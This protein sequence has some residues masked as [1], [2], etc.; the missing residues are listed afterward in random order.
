[1]VLKVKREDVMPEDTDHVARM[2][3]QM[4]HFTVRDTGIG[5]AP[6][7]LGHA[8]RGVHAGGCLDDAQVRRHGAGAGDL[9]AAERDDGRDDV[10]RERRRPGP[11]QCLPL[12]HPGRGRAR[13][14]GAAAPGRRAGGA[15][16]QA[17]ADRG[18]QRHQPAHPAPAD[19]ELGHAAA[20]DG[21]SAGSAGVGSRAEIRS[22][23]RSWTCTCRSWTAWSWRRRSGRCP[24]GRSSRCCWPRRW[25]YPRPGRRA[26]CSRPR[27]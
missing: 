1:M 22:T 20:R 9:Q 5:I 15:A 11:G 13:D 10:G 6:D 4:L 8:V 23:W 24:K 3:N 16:R 25:A 2:P 18:R 17:G 27:C 26:G 19:G 14:Q 21:V 12:H 7:R